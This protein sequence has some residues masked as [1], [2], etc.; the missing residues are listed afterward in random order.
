MNAER[1][2][3]TTGDGGP[4]GP[5]GPDAA[6]HRWDR[7][8]RQVALRLVLLAGAYVAWAA[9]VLVLVALS[10]YSSE[11]VSLVEGHAA[12][13]T[14][15]TSTVYQ[16][17]PGPVRIILALLGGALVVSTASVWWRVARRSTRVGAA[18]MTAG[19]IA[20]S[21]ALL[22][23]LTIGPFVLPLA[24]LLVILALPIAPDRRPPPPAHGPV[25]PG[26]VGSS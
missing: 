12:R 3:A 21:I 18:G 10:S 6:P 24:A 7:R 8:T 26:W 20:G 23:M 17:D 14:R 11:S 1:R 4:R 13:V 15:S 9:L 5:D 22:G 25:P 2:R 19:A 16:M